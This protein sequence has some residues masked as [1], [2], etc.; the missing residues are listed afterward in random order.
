MIRKLKKLKLEKKLEKIL[1]KIL[2]KNNNK[3]IK[4]CLIYSIIPRNMMFL[5]NKHS[6]FCQEYIN[7]FLIQK[8]EYLLI[9]FNFIKKIIQNALKLLEKY[10]ILIK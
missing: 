5:K 9:L 6:R 4:L 1:E 8:D 3:K 2:E 7:M 10:N